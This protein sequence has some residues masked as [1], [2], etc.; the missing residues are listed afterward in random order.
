MPIVFGCI[1]PHSIDLIPEFSP[2]PNRLYKT[3]QAMFKMGKMIERLNPTTIIILTPHGFR[4]DG[5]VSISVSEYASGLL[6]RNNVRVPFNFEIDTILAHK[7][8]DVIGNSY[9]SLAKYTF[10]ASKGLDSNI[11]LDW[12]SMVPL[13]F[14]ASSIKTVPKV[15]L[16]CPAHNVSL[17]RL[18]Q[19]GQ[20][21]AQSIQSM[22]EKIAIVASADQAHT[23]HVEGPYGFNPGAAI[24]DQQI[25]NIVCQSEFHKIM[26][27]SP[28]LVKDTMPDSIWQLAILGGVLSVQ[29]FKCEILSYEINKY[30]GMLSAMFYSQSAL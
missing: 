18:F 7:L 27:L 3:R 29:S 26:K 17:P 4:V 9:V 28:Q 24:F 23:H 14:L 11:P 20:I 13:R 5:M 19:L 22:P 6:T 15:I 1:A 16:V 25:E 8:I 12:G 10:G 30:F 2:R 21:M